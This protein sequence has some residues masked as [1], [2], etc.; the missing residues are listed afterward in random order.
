M[1]QTCMGARQKDETLCMIKANIHSESKWWDRESG[2]WLLRLNFD[3]LHFNSLSQNHEKLHQNSDSLS[4]KS[5]KLAPSL[6]QHLI[7]LTKYVKIV[8]QCEYFYDIMSNFS[9]SFWGE[10]KW[11]VKL[12]N[13]LKT[14]HSFLIL[15]LNCKTPFPH[16]LRGCICHS[17]ETL[18]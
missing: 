7:I 13:I 8:T 17:V 14:T 4:H 12:Y 11:A 15:A 9:C 10:Q 2:C 6:T 18:S 16:E 1:N 3:L 5:N